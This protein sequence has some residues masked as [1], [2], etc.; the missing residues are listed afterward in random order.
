MS[1]QRG[2]TLIELSLAF[3][4]LAMTLGL[5]LA[6]SG[7]VQKQMQQAD[8]QNQ[9]VMY[10]ESLIDDLGYGVVIQEQQRE[11]VFTDARFRWHLDIHKQ[12][13]VELVKPV[14]GYGPTL[15]QVKV[16]VF[17]GTHKTVWHTLRSAYA[18]NA[19]AGL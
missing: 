15:Y 10:G 6:V 13:D 8:M 1:R 14:K 18:V 19:Q 5:L 12:T 16:T 7:R 4:L 3:V 9:A 2:F 17:W 11:G